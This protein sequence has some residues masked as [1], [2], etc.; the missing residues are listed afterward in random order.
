MN[1]EGFAHAIARTAPRTVAVRAHELAPL[2]GE[3]D[4]NVAM[5]GEAIRQAA[6]DE[7]QLLVL[8]ELATSGYYLE[9]VEAE[10]CALPAEHPLFDSW[11]NQL[12]PDMVLVV[13][14]CERADNE[15]FNS[16]A[17]ITRAGLQTV[18]RKT[19]LWDTEQA[20]FSRGKHAPPVVQTPAGAIGVLICYDLEFPEMPRSLALRGAEII[21]VP[22]NWPLIP[23]PDGEHA[24]E[25][26]QGMAAA[27]A[28]AMAIICCDRRGTER[29]HPWTQ[30]TAVIGSDGWLTGSIGPSG[31]L[32]AI[33][34]I[35]AD[36]TRIGPHNDSLQDRRPNLYAEGL[37]DP[38]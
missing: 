6:A 5:I 22:T 32:D 20:I 31:K 7:V 16:A 15:L 18:Y 21:A 13:G 3:L 24:P 1:P 25:V 29:G 23:R 14:F 10:R 17:V 8:P 9:P 2:V 12:T 19:H 38:R 37:V 28:S 11:A 30:G 4:M 34:S 27:R 36:R 35:T 26:I 33:V